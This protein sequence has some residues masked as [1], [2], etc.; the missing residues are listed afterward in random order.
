MF[1]CNAQ[2]CRWPLPSNSQPINVCLPPCL[3]NFALVLSQFSSSISSPRSYFTWYHIS[4]PFIT[5]PPT[6]HF[7]QISTNILLR[8]NIHQHFTSSKYLPTL[9][10]YQISINIYF[11][12]NIHQHFTNSTKYIPI[13]H[14]YQISTNITLPSNI[15]TNIYFLPNIH[16]HFTSTKHPPTFLLCQCPP[17]CNQHF[18]S[19]SVDR[20]F[21]CSETVLWTFT[22]FS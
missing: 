16:Q 12:T 19:M 10:F 6:F 17:K 18:S 2:L 13:L 1:L 7:F 9:H 4:F 21:S 14:F 20:I 3:T 22:F 8:P 11:L 5:H 15:Y